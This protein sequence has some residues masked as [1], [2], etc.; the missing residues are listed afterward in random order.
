MRSFPRFTASL[1]LIQRPFGVSPRLFAEASQLRSSMLSTGSKSAPS[2]TDGMSRLPPVRPMFSL[3]L[4]LADD[5]PLPKA[6]SAASPS[7]STSPEAPDAEKPQ[8]SASSES[9]FGSVLSQPSMPRPRAKRARAPRPAAK[10]LLFITDAAADRIKE[11]IAEY[12]A[13]HPSDPAPMGMRLGVRRRGCNGQSYT[14]DF[15][16]DNAMHE[17][18]KPTTTE[19]AERGVRVF[20]NEDAVM[21]VVGTEMD[22]V[23]TLL[24]EDFQFKNPNATG[25]CGCGESFHM[26]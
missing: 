12:S 26:D 10:Q 11:L 21:A 20:V 3:D 5:P 6:P 2:R 23:R 16:F 17:K 14:L 4:A 22:F 15:E 25:Q 7:A 8:T 13:E 1:S 18:R 19:V 24:S 9:E